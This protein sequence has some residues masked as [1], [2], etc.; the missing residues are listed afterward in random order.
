MRAIVMLFAV[1][2]VFCISRPAA[3][4]EVSPLFGY[5]EDSFAAAWKKLS[6]K[7]AIRDGLYLE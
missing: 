6:P 7:P 2:A 3:A 4:I 5:D 1:L